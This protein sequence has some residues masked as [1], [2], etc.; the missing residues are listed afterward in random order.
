[1][2]VY[3]FFSYVRIFQDIWGLNLRAFPD[4]NVEKEEDDGKT[5]S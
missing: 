3:I 4:N 1:M 2:N 5:P